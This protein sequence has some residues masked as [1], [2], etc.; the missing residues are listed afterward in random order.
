MSSAA[1]ASMI[2]AEIAE[3]AGNL[4]LDYFREGNVTSDWKHDYSIVTE[5]DVAADRLIASGLAE[6]FPSDAILSEELA[7]T[8]AL[9]AARR[10]AHTWIVDPLDGTTNFSLG[11]QHWGVSIARTDSSGPDVGVLYFPA[12]GEMYVASRGSGATMNGSAIHVRDEADARLVGMLACCARTPRHYHV[13]LPM[14]VRVFGSAAYTLACVA[15]GSASIGMETRPKI[16]DLA[17]GWCLV[18]EAGGVVA[19]IDG[20]EPFPLVA[21]HAYADRSFPVV[22]AASPEL[23]ARARESIEPR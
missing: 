22:A 21:D 4:L 12:L 19:T 8:S 11:V 6:H 10:S 7:P 16:W 23:L 1:A 5:A 3:R 15:R 20:S 9:E 17:A 18:E 13:N 14:K 2:A